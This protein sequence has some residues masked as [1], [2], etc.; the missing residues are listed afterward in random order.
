MVIDNI[1]DELELDES[2]RRR[3]RELVLQALYAL[4][5]G[6]ADLA[7]VEAD[8]LDDSVLSK[9][10]QTFTNHFFALVREKTEWADK[11]ISDLSANWDIERL[12]AIDHIVLKM[13]LVELNFMPDSP[14]R[15]CI[16]EAIELGKKYS[17]A[18]SASFI[19]GLLD[20]YATRME[21]E[22]EA[23]E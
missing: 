17:T 7:Y 8:I 18:G 10:N 14:V 3:A 20:S 11:I 12:A 22:R 16:N 2:P 21:K 5:I 13:A 4:E 23:A 19:N 1:H 9:K 6:E 15:V